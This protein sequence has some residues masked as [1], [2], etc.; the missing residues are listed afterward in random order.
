MYTKI[1]IYSAII[2]ISD[3]G[4][5]Q[6]QGIMNCSPRFAKKL[7]LLGKSSNF[8]QKYFNLYSDLEFSDLILF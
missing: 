5:G 4:N 8:A 7:K 1:I 3:K 2:C 6:K